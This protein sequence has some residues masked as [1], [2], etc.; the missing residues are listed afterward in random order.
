[1]G[2]G[3]APS[4]RM[5]AGRGPRQIVWSLQESV[6]LSMSKHSQIRC[7]RPA[8]QAQARSANA[9]TGAAASA[10]EHE[11]PRNLTDRA[12][13]L[14]GW[15]RHYV[16]RPITE[17]EPMAMR[18]IAASLIVVV[19][20]IGTPRV[21]VAQLSMQSEEAAHPGLVRAIHEMQEALKSLQHAPD[22]FGGNKAQAITDLRAAIHST[23]KALYYRLNL[24]DGAIDRIP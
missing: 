13:P 2:E 24:D 23:R 20:L 12:L 18:L 22:N 15:M 5:R 3:L 11:A 14:A 9:I 1:M 16:F 6:L 19:A 21:A 7:P 8:S 4:V 17:D 10:A